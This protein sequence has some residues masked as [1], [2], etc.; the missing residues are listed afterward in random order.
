ML[1]QRN[2]QLTLTY[3]DVHGIPLVFV[4]QTA[5]LQNK[6]TCIKSQFSLRAKRCTTFAEIMHFVT[7]P[8]QKHG[9]AEQ[10]VVRVLE[11]VQNHR[12]S[13][14]NGEVQHAMVTQ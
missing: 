8:L 12:Q 5:Y 13:L 14:N 4:R 7:K 9:M 11:H 10:R 6:S 3:P 2:A 1:V